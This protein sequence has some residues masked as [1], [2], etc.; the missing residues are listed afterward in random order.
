MA[1]IPAPSSNANKLTL[2]EDASYLLKKEEQQ[3][4]ESLLGNADPYNR[5]LEDYFRDAELAFAGFP[6]EL[7]RR[8]LEFRDFGNTEGV[9]LVRGMPRDPVVPPTPVEP[10]IYPVRSTYYG[11]F[12]MACIA[13]ALGQPVGY[14]QEKA[15]RIF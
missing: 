7:R 10:E 4:I 12:L 3:Q 13:R 1:A 5:N 11:A 6:D 9:L 15:G 2:A 8:I 14:L